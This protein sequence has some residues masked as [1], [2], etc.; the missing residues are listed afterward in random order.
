[1]A[2]VAGLLAVLLLAGACS[3]AKNGKSSGTA[4]RTDKNFEEGTLT[5]SKTGREKTENTSPP[6]AT[7]GRG[8]VSPGIVL[9]LEGDPKTTFSGICTVGGK[10][11]V[12]SGRVPKRYVF[13]VKSLS[14]RIQKQNSGKGSLKAI[15]TANNT[16]RS[17]QQTST[18]GG[19]IHISYTGG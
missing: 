6:E 16:T 17:V 11:N 7:L 2:F 5:S 14:C 9:R 8:P 3:G 13:K 1:M 10:E 4:D 18:R 12:L 19:V 15:L